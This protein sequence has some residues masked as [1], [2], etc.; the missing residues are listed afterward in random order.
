[1]HG[2]ELALQVSRQFGKDDAVLVERRL[3]VLAVGLAVGRLVEV[4]QAP[5]PARHLHTFEAE[6]RGPGR[7]AVE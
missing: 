7:D 6:S 5:V 3:Q 2:D 1:V 4:E